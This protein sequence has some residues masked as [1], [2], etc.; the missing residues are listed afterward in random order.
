MNIFVYGWYNHSNLGDESYKISFRKIWPEHHFTFCDKVTDNCVDK[1]DLCIIGGGDVIV[2]KNLVYISRFNCPKI[3]LSVTITPLSL[4]PEIHVLNHIYVRDISSYNNLITYGHK[5]V[6]L[7]PDI[8]IILQGNKEQGLNL[9]RQIF[10]KNGSD[11]YNKVYTININ[12]HLIGKPDTCSKNNNMFYKMLYDIVEVIDKT[13]A[14]FLFLPFGT[15]L[16]WDDRVSNG[17]VNSYTKFHKKNCV[18]YDILSLQD[19]LDIMSAS[20]MI[21]TSRFHGLIFGIGN[22]VPTIPISFHDKMKGYCN[23]INKRYIDYWN[24]SSFELKEYMDEVVS[25]NIDI[26]KIK[27]EYREKVHILHE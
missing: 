2:E 19:S 13:N 9:I 22:N 3:A 20:D 7:I 6:T 11:K 5:N 27:D 15:S 16:P 12:S 8:S 24:F 21:I 4:M 23:T 14:S 26:K 17:L 1:Y 18:I 25:E 10:E